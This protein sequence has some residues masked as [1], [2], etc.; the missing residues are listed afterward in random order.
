[1]GEIISEQDR[2][3][4]TE[5]TIGLSK[6]ITQ[7]SRSTV[8]SQSVDAIAGLLT[9]EARPV[10]F[11]AAQALAYLGPPVAV[12]SLPA[13]KQALAIAKVEEAELVNKYGFFGGPLLSDV[14]QSALFR[15]GGFPATAFPVTP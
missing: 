4:R 7:E 5:L 10:R 14:I 1:V 9:D 13:L 6:S 12:R 8:D 15:I 3:K 2:S 11:W